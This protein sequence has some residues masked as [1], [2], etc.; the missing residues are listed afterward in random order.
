MQV[1]L[2]VLLGTEHLATLLAGKVVMEGVSDFQVAT[3]VILRGV[4]VAAP[5]TRALVCPSVHFV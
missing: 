5:M 3:H 4:D 1:L 2:V